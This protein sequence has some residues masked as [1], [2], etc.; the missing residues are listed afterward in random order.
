[1]ELKRKTK[2]NP[3]ALF[4]R[5]GW[6]CPKCGGVM[7]PYTVQCPNCNPSR[8]EIKVVPMYQATRTG[9]AG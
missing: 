1:M 5:M 9:E 4:G 8:V 6:E 3:K 2:P 7:S